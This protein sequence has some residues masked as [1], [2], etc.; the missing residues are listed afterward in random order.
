MAVAKTDYKEE[1][2]KL[3]NEE[4][5]SKHSLDD[6]SR[7]DFVRIEN[8]VDSAIS[9]GEEL[10]LQKIC[11]EYY[12]EN[13][14]SIFAIY[15]IGLILL[16]KGSIDTYYMPEVLLKFSEHRKLSISVFIA[17]KILSYREEKYALKLLEEYYRNENRNDELVDIKERLVRVD[18]KDAYTPKSLAEYYEEEGNVQKALYY[19]KIALERFIQSK[20]SSSVA[21][22]FEKI[23]SFHSLLDH[24]YVLNISLRLLDL[25]SHEKIGKLLHKFAIH[26]KKKE[27]YDKALEVLKFVISRCTPNDA[28]VRNDLREVYE[29]LYPNHS[30]LPKY[31][32]EFS[33]FMRRRLHSNIRV[34]Y[35][36]IIDKL[37]ELEKKLRFDI[38]VYV[39][40]KT[41]GVGVISDVQDEWLV[42]DFVKKQGHRMFSN[43]AFY[44]LDVLSQDDVRVWK[45]YKKEELDK[46]IKSKSP[47]VIK[48]V[49]VSLGGKGNV[50]DIK[51]VLAGLMPES[52]VNQFWNSVKHSLS[53]VNVVVSPESRNTYVYLGEGKVEEDIKE[54]LNTLKTFSE[55][56]KFIYNFLQQS[57]TL[58]VPQAQPIVEFLL[59]VVNNSSNK[60][61]IV[62]AGILLSL[63]YSGTPQEVKEKV[64]HTM[65]SMDENSVVEFLKVA[66]INEVKKS[67]LSTIR[68][69]LENWDDVFV[70]VVLSVEA[71]RLNNYIMS[72][73]VSYD[74]IDAIKKIVSTILE[75]ANNPSSNRFVVYSKFMWFAKIVFQKEYEDVFKLLQVDKVNILLTVA[76]IL[77]SIQYSFE[78]RG[79]KGISKRI[80]MMAKEVFSNYNDVG[81][82][83]IESGKDTAFLILSYI[84]EFEL[85]E[86][87]EL[88]NLRQKLYYKYPDLKYM[89][90]TRDRRS[91]FMITRS[92]YEKIREEYNRILNEELPKVSKMLSASHSAELVEKEEELKALAEQLAKELSEYKI[93]NPDAVSK[94]YVDVG[95]KVVLKSKKTGEEIV[96]HILGDKDANIEKNIISYRS[97]LG[98]KLMDKEVGD[99]VQISIKGA[100]EEFQIKSISLSE[101]V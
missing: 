81:K 34:N 40:H 98:V 53:E 68:T 39:Y 71:V 26:F 5:I 30:L 11:E 79:E 61:E 57:D 51:E 32:N 89:E 82:V 35:S 88:S 8:I 87:R 55:Q 47:E 29:S 76:N 25:V 83:I 73:L 19:Y 33:E 46:L 65:R 9:A 23:L 62:E 49:L 70:K 31:F 4:K 13:T 24:K 37:N 41:F 17:E 22:V 43:I 44:S 66:E 97:P 1:M 6:Y 74:K 18:P 54:T 28:G 72:E 58:D 59:N 21:S 90:D 101:Y 56:M 27:S 86:P 77:S 75:S 12:L 16:K 60:F 67:F 36:E 95:T 45:E 92:T 96:Y 10:E 93:I 38:G 3:F 78:E 64:L 48:M 80:Y 20:N 85:L 7:K 91:P 2:T 52:D 100:E 94:N 84:Q 63:K 15:T 99:V 14:N 50:K 69:I 42:I